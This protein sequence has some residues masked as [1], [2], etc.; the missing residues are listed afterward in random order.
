MTTIQVNIDSS[1]A[2]TKLRRLFDVAR[3]PGPLLTALGRTAR[4]EL[5]G[6]FRHKHKVNPNK[7]GGRRQNFWLKIARSTNA[8][9]VNAADR[10]VTVAITDPRFGHK[11][12][13]G[14]IRAKRV[15]FLTIP[16]TPEAY[17]RSARTFEA[18]TGKSLFFLWDD[19]GGVLAHADDPGNV[20]AHFLLRRSVNQKA[21]PTALPD[22]GP[23]SP[24]LA[25]LETSAES[26]LQRQLNPS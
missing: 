20:T 6:H 3:K 14:V 10:S 8:P 19:D 22:M 5:V 12:F 7:L 1:G 13:G 9:K 17:G 16:L 23:N 24:F 15:K 4:N 18:E 2:D 21:D 25:A 11:L 26:A